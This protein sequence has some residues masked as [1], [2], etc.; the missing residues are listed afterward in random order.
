MAIFPPQAQ[1]EP[2]AP[3]AGCCAAGL[4]VFSPKALSSS[5]P[6][7]IELHPGQNFGSKGGFGLKSWAES[8]AGDGGLEGCKPRNPRCS[9]GL[10]FRC[11]WALS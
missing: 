8:R 2:W 3:Q 5:S 6:V 7:E 11:L 1:S 9:L 10:N 4:E